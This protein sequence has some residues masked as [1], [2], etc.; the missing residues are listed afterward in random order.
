MRKSDALGAVG[1]AGVVA[2]LMVLGLL[3]LGGSISK[4]LSTVGSSIGSAQ[5]VP[6]APAGGNGVPSVDKP[7]PNPAKPA[8]NPGPKDPPLYDVSTPD[9]LIIKT[10]SLS[11]QVADVDAALAGA[12]GRIGGLG[13]YASGSQRQGEGASAVASVTYRIPAARWDDA[14]VTLR[15]L[16]IKVVA[17]KT[18]TDDVTGKVADIGARITS[19]QATERALQAIMVQATKIADIL[20]VQA[21]L[22]DVQGQI[23]QLTADRKHLTEQAAYSTLTV[24][25]GLKEQAV[26]ATTSSF[27]PTSEVDRAGARLIHL[28]Q[29]VVTVAIWFAI[30]WLP[31]LVGLAIVVLIGYFLARRFGRRHFGPGSA[32]PE[33]VGTPTA[34]A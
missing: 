1:V 8:A 33:S 19:F 22:T 29:K 16:A 20:A 27:D 30:V 34:G 28:L 2:T 17:E 32:G 3:F 9:L 13:G 10:G 18:Q 11:L 14:L 25:F 6:V 15:G 26:V 24:G 5:G 7:A 12:A 23:E 31:F 21:Q 4:V